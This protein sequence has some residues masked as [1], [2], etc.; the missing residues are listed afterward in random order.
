MPPKKKKSVG[1]DFLAIFDHSL[2][3]K[4]AQR[5]RAALKGL[6]EAKEKAGEKKLTG[7]DENNGGDGAKT[8]GQAPEP[9]KK[10]EDNN[11]GKANDNDNAN[12]DWTAEEDAKLLELK[13]A[14]KSTWAQI[15]NELGK[16]A[17]EVKKRFKEINKPAEPKDAGADQG[18]PNAG[19]DKKDGDDAKKDNNKTKK[20]NQ[21]GGA[22]DKDGQ[23]HTGGKKNK[24]KGKNKG[25]QQANKDSKPGQEG[26]GGKAKSKSLSKGKEKVQKAD[27][28]DPAF[29]LTQYTSMHGD[30]M[31]SYEELAMLGKLVARDESRDWLRIA[32][33][34]YDKTGRR[35][36]S[37]DVRERFEG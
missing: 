10:N 6:G 31:F 15:A 24:G 9:S 5:Y 17:W 18:G 28:G 13:T 25:D 27:G 35:V 30:E 36:H 26:D 1:C 12:R 2:N 7:N 34:F 16:P 29:T 11:T 32:S 3:G 23:T 19:E 33:R 20:G 21:G 37:D 4:T 14:S 8:A 22:G